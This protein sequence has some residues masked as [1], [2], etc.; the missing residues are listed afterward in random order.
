MRARFD[1]AVLHV[2]VEGQRSTHLGLESKT[3]AVSAA[4]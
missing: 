2:N 3:G 4:G 1:T